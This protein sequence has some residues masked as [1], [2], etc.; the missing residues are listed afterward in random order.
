MGE[1]RT[2]LQQEETG[3]NIKQIYASYSSSAQALGS[4][5]S[6][7][8]P[9]GG[10]PHIQAHCGLVQGPPS[11]GRPGAAPV[12]ALVGGWEIGRTTS[13][14]VPPG[15]GRLGRG[16]YEQGLRRG[17]LSHTVFVAQKPRPA[18][19]GWARSQ[20]G[21]SSMLSGPAAQPPL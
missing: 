1:S 6:P 16:W 9:A 19:Q 14:L 5:S 3:V 8:E 21:L 10:R 11:P 15:T 4:A 20:T 2:V 17:P 18:A 7:S 13:S 12:R